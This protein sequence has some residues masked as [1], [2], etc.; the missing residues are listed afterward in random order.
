MTFWSPDPQEP[1]LKPWGMGAKRRAK[2]HDGLEG[3]PAKPSCLLFRVETA[4]VLDKADLV[5]LGQ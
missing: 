5:C 4:L 2:T 1:L 3:F